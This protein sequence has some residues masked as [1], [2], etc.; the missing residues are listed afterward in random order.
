M[1]AS[2]GTNE[3]ILTHM[4]D[5]FL[6]PPRAKQLSPNSLLYFIRNN[7]NF[8]I[9]NELIEKTKMENFFSNESNAVT[10][11]LPH[12][13]AFKMLNDALT[14]KADYAELK[15]L[16]M[17]HVAR[18]PIRYESMR[19]SV[20]SIS[21]Y[22]TLRLPLKISG[23]TSGVNVGP[24][25]DAVANQTMSRLYQSSIEDDY[26]NIKVGDSIIHIISLPLIPEIVN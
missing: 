26:T 11:F 14:R 15:D 19:G 3:D 18:S 10:L 7:R 5:P 1:S 17:F 22:H 2:H 23:L 12:D 21:T 4:T 8:K 9:F 13:N 6:A 16:V 20:G 25:H 24:Y